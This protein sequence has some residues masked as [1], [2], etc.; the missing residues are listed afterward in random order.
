[1]AVFCRPPSP[2]FY[3]Y[4]KIG[5]FIITL[6]LHRFWGLFRIASVRLFERVPTIYVLSNTK[7]NI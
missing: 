2:H 5:G 7:K 3:T 4:S 6:F 1:M